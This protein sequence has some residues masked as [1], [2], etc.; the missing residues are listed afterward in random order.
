[1]GV[2]GLDGYQAGGLI[3]DYKHDFPVAAQNQGIFRDQKGPPW[4]TDR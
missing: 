3:D 1:M 4:I 2:T